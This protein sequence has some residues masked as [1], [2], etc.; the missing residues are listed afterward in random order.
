[1]TVP[2]ALLPGTVAHERLSGTATRQATAVL[3]QDV[4][5]EV[6]ARW[7]TADGTPRS[8]DVLAPGG[9]RTGARVTMW[10]DSA[11]R[12]APPPSTGAALRWMASVTVGV[13]VIIGGLRV[14][15]H[16]AVRLA[17]DRGRLSAWQAEWERVERDWTHRC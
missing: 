7:T 13:L 11:G 9:A 2:P 6:H 5:Q 8:G 14:L 16:G 17:L 1:M 15:L 3:E 12:P 10:L 4:S